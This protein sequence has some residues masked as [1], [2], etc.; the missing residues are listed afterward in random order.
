MDEGEQGEGESMKFWELA[1]L[2]IGVAIV[3]GGAAI[4]VVAAIGL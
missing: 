4:I 1:A 3:V 2:V